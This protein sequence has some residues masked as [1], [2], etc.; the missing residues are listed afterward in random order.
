MLPA[1]APA[2][3]NLTTKASKSEMQ[4]TTVHLSAP[5]LVAPGGTPC[6]MPLKL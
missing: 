3:S 2:D 1:P 5:W 4:V 6:A